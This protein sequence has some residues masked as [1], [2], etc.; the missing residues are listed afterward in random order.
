MLPND[1]IEWMIPSR[2]GFGYD[3][4]SSIITLARQQPEWPLPARETEEGDGPQGASVSGF[5]NLHVEEKHLADFLT[6]TL[7]MV[8]KKRRDGSEGGVCF[9]R[10]ELMAKMVEKGYSV[11]VEDKVGDTGAGGGHGG[12]Y[13]AKPKQTGSVQHGWS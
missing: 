6:R 3:P 9:G 4:A 13:A 10:D 2:S 11:V 1:R 5:S 12:R 7:G 8:R